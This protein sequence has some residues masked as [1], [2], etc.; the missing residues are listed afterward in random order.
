MPNGKPLRT[1]LEILNAF[2]QCKAFKSPTRYDFLGITQRELW[3][4]LN[5][6]RFGPWF[7]YTWDPANGWLTDAG[8]AHLAK[9]REYNI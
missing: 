4:I 2:D 6:P 7:D 8:K 5:K 1:D 3:M 9:L